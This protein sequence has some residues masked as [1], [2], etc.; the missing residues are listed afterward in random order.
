MFL[1]KVKVPAH[2]NTVWR[3]NNNNDIGFYVSGATWSGN[4]LNEIGCGLK[5]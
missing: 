2:V 3:I 5:Y 1:R 4:W